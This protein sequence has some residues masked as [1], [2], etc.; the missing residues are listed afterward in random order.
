MRGSP[1]GEQDAYYNQDQ[2]G[3]MGY[4]PQQQYGH[5]DVN[6]IEFICDDGKPLQIVRFDKSTG[7]FTLEPEAVNVLP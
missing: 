4:D 6:E 2:G 7:K 3:Q 5:E 1:Y